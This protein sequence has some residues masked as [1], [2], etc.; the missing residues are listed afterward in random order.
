MSGGVERKLHIFALVLDLDHFNYG[1]GCA[2]VDTVMMKIKLCICRIQLLSHKTMNSFLNVFRL[3]VYVY[4]C[5]CVGVFRLCILYISFSALNCGL[6]SWAK[7]CGTWV[8]VLQK[9]QI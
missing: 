9:P 4:V 2:D 8:K 7:S 3:I 1:C 5:F 6:M